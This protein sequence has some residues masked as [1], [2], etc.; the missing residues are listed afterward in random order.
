[1]KKKK[2]TNTDNRYTVGSIEFF[3]NTV[4]FVLSDLLMEQWNMVK[5]DRW[6]LNT[7]LIDIKCTVKVN[8]NQCNIIQVIV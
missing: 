3:R 2:S 1:M 5:K 6:S 4:K 7:G 8:K